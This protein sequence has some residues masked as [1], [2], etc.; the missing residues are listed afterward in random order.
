MS[1]IANADLLKSLQQWYASQC[2][3]AWEHIC[4][5]SID[6]LDNPGWSVKIDIADTYLLGR[7]FDEVRVEGAN[8][9]DWYVCKVENNAFKAMGGPNRLF[10]VIA[11]FIEWA[12]KN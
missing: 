1:A 9:D 4:G 6:T 5:I 2:N 3:G 11:V 12:Y 7:T 10:D 8:K